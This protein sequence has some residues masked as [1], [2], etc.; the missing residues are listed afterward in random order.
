MDDNSKTIRK[1]QL[2]NWWY[3]HKW[4]VI[5]ALVLIF[6]LA[7]I[8]KNALHIGE[9]E[10]DYRIAYVG[11][12]ALPEDTVTQ[13]KSSLEAL[14]ED[15][16]HD[17]RVLFEINQYTSNENAGSDSAYYKYAAEV[18][19]IA[20]LDECESFFFLL[21]DPDGF[22]KGYGS[23]A[24]LDGSLPAEDAKDFEN[25]YISW[26]DSPL[27][28]SLELGAY[29]TDTLGMEATGSSDELMKK[30][31]IARRGFWTEKACKNVEGCEELW[32]KIC[33]VNQ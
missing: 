26:N 22:E 13:L 11:M 1:K 15:L 30:L 27:L 24:Y 17:G 6:S 2:A 8:L 16:N 20:D 29:Q 31:Y 32:S 18:L 10:P 7:D 9:T 19:L 14:G 12:N 33:G 21:E 23:L 5:I 28:S 25:M 3:Y 4:H